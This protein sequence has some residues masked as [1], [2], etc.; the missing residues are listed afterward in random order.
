MGITDVDV[1]YNGCW[2]AVIDINLYLHGAPIMPSAVLLH[3]VIVSVF[4]FALISARHKGNTSIF[5]HDAHCTNCNAVF[6]DSIATSNAKIAY[7]LSLPPP[8]NVRVSLYDFMEPHIGC[9]LES[10]DGYGDGPKWT[11]GLQLVTPPCLVFSVGSNCEFAFEK[12]IRSLP[13]SSQCDLHIF[14]PFV[15]CDVNAYNATFHRVGLGSVSHQTT[16]RDMSGRSMHITKKPFRAIM[17][18][19]SYEGRT[20]DVL[21]VD[22]EGDEYDMFNNQ[23]FDDIKSAKLRIHQIQIELHRQHPHGGFDA[24]HSFAMAM[25]D[26][27]F[28]L[29]H[30]ERNG[31]GADANSFVEFSFISTEWFATVFRSTR[32]PTCPPL[33]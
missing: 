18:E 32:C 4:A 8:T 22:I 14:D 7:A 25:R 5:Q 19:L 3:A 12:T 11:C 30:K 10:R 29:F 21:K 23:L 15:T 27:G 1:C 31:W 16:Q 2:C 6:L 17:Q 20:V 13:G 26:A 33:K 28:H 9:D 24:V